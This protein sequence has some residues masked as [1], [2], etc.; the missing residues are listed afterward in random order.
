MSKK[1]LSKLIALCVVASTISIG[2][3]SSN[4]VKADAVNGD[5][6][7]STTGNA[8][9]D[10]TLNNPTTFEA[11]LTKVAPGGTIYVMGGTYTYN[12]QIT[13]QRGNDGQA[14]KLKNIQP[15]ED[16][17]VVL[18][19]SSETYGNPSKV[20]NARGLQVNGNY[21]HVKGI[22]VKGAADNGIYV[23]G[24]NNLFELC[25]TDYNRDAG[26]QVGRYAKNVPS[27][28]WP[29]NNLILNCTSHD[30][31]DPDNG[32]DA[33]GFACK[34][35]VGPGN[36]FKGCIS[37]HNIDDGWDL[38]AKKATGAIAPVTIEDCVAYNNGATSNGTSTADSDGNGFKLGGDKIAVSHVV[39]N[40]V[41]F[42]NKKHG[43]T[44]NSNP[45]SI[46]LTNC[47]GYNNGS[48]KGSNFS[49]DNG[50]AILTNCLSYKSSAND[51]IS[52]N[53]TI[54]SNVFWSTDHKKGTTQVLCTDKDFVS[55]TPYVG[56]N[57]DGTIDL[58]DFLKL[59][60][61]SKFVGAGVGGANIGA[62]FSVIK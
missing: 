51:K 42:N 27:N 57:A 5:V 21:W 29:S 14:D 10:G 19:F 40:C 18:D 26:F 6:Y 4:L 23:A 34:L 15:Y 41:S 3:F 9:A 46:S 37:H 60:S 11:A 8:N 36:V 24:N 61:T 58:G 52:A 38:Y 13:I 49:F 20:S 56:R 53:A 31:A 7:V 12:N 25:E 59:S 39:K 16:G 62:T 54:K 22:E 50:T 55:I 43:F 30:N 47:T 2:S 35:T 45:G 33:D 48:T 28:N 17:K 1:R 32:E 44:F